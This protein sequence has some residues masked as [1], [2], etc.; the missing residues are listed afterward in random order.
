MDYKRFEVEDYSKLDLIKEEILDFLK[1][2]KDDEVLIKPNL[3]VKYKKGKDHI[4]TD[5]RF[6]NFVVE[7]LKDLGVKKIYLGESSGAAGDFMN[8]T[9][10]CLDAIEEH[11]K[12]KERYGV[13]YVNFDKADVVE[14]EIMGLK[15]KFPA[16]IKDVRVLNLPKF[17]THVLT[18]FTAAVKNNYGFIVSSGKLH[19]H[20]KISDP[21]KFVD[22]L[23]ELVKF[24]NPTVNLVD[25]IIVMDGQGPIRGIPKRSGN[26]FISKTGWLSSLLVDYMMAYYYG[27]EE[28]ADKFKKVLMEDNVDLTKYKLERSKFYLSP[29]GFIKNWLMSLM[30]KIGGFL[31]GRSHPVWNK[32]KCK[33]CK[34]CERICPVKA[35]KVIPKEKVEFN[36]DKCIRC[37]ACMENCD[38]FAISWE[39]PWLLRIYRGNRN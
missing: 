32:E 37:G 31:I 4:I 1:F 15:L 10:S 33:Y 11:L 21:K 18:G 27:L 25:A 24:I 36:L 13:E 23:I 6:I 8:F 26:V 29:P 17:K 16:L 19:V 2:L 28:F 20:N 9:Q 5:T 14:K 39:E 12:L 7:V 35:I 22:F 34:V 3:V 38:F 30:L